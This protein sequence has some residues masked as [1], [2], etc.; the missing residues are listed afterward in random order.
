MQ[1]ILQEVEEKREKEKRNINQNKIL[2]KQ[3]LQS[4]SNEIY[5]WNWQRNGT[6]E[7][8]IVLDDGRFDVDIKDIRSKGGIQRNTGALESLIEP[9]GFFERRR[10]RRQKQRS[11]IDAL[12]RRALAEEEAEA[13][14]RRK[15]RRIEIV[16]EGENEN[17]S[18][19]ETKNE[20]I[21]KNRNQSRTNQDQIEQHT[22]KQKK[23]GEESKDYKKKHKKDV[24]TNINR[25]NLNNNKN[26]KQDI[27]GNTV[28]LDD[29]SSEG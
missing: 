15:R 12:E 14:K 29:S 4:D 2:I 5:D 10:L 3:D 22:I 18:E 25:K 20:K 23:V 27:A 11:E 26:K 24:P 16:D 28:I 13:A 8:V 9:G 1:R 17:D 6:V 7:R 21:N 19:T